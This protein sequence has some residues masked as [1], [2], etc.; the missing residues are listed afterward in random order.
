MLLSTHTQDASS[1]SKPFIPYHGRRQ[2]TFP[3]YSG[4]K[5]QGVKTCSYNILGCQACAKIVI[6]NLVLQDSLCSD[7][8][9]C[10]TKNQEFRTD[11]LCIFCNVM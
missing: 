11:T 2:T 4:S 3:L 8:S 5:V 9:R 7:P 10:L 1:S 6:H